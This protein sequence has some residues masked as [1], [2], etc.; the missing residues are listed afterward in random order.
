MYGPMYRLSPA[1]RREVEK[2]VKEYLAQ[3]FIENSKSSHA[4]PVVFVAKKDGTLRM[5]IDHR[6][7]NNKTVKNK[8]PLP[9]IDDLHLIKCRAA[10][11]LAL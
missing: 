9:R 5:C 7:L 3:D 8:Y 11:T 2:Q 1:E 10:L 6:T 4:P